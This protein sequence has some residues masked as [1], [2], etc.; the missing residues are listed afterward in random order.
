MVVATGMETELGRIAD[1]HPGRG[2]G[3]T[4]LQQRLDS[5]GKMLAAGGAIAALL[6]LLVGWC[7]RGEALA[8]MFLTAVSV[9]VAVVPEGLPAVVTITLA[10][11][12]QRMLRR[13]ALIRKLPAVETLGS[14]T[15]ICSDKTGTLTENRMTVTVVDVAGHG[16]DLMETLRTPHADRHGG[17]MPHLRRL[18]PAAAHP[19][20]AGRRRPVQRCRA[21]AGCRPRAASTPSATR[22][23]GRCW[24]RRP[25]RGCSR[26]ACGPLR[27]AWP[28]CRLTPSASA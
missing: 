2:P 13:N 6:V 5:L 12:A 21:Q 28:R 14:V 24:W 3:T 15:V 7:A 26:T 18:G 4:P 20:G 22:P 9:A 19:P 8:D 10:L 23:R 16:L 25:A 1:A 11:G 17:R 27:R